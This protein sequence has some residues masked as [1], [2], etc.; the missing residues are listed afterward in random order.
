[1][2]GL[3]RESHSIFIHPVLRSGRELGLVTRIAYWIM[4]AA[5]VALCALLALS[6]FPPR[7]R[8]IGIGLGLFATLYIATIWL[9]P[10]VFQRFMVQPNAAEAQ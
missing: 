3:E 7:L 9:A 1:V 2:E 4:L 8:S 5:A 10:A 6:F